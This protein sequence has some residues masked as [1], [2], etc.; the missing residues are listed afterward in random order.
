MSQQ[1]ILW[2]A[3]NS[4]SNTTTQYTNPLGHG[5]TFDTEASQ[6]MIVATGG[7]FSNLRAVLAAAP[8]VGKSW[9]ITLRVNGSSS[10]LTVAISGASTDVSDIAHSVSVSPGDVIA[11]QFTPAGTPA[12]GS[13]PSVSLQFDSTTPGASMYG[14]GSNNVLA[15]TRNNPLFGG[16]TSTN[17][18]EESSVN[19]VE[20]DLTALYVSL[21]GAPG[22]G[23]YTF[24]IEK[25]GTLQDGSGGTVDTRVTITGAGTAGNTSFT[26]PCTPGDL[27]R[28]RGTPS[29][30]GTTRRPRYG[31]AL[32]SDTPGVSNFCASPND[33][34]DATATEYQSPMGNDSGTFNGT[35]SARQATAGVAFVLNHLRFSTNLAP[36]AGKS[37]TLTLRINGSSSAL[38][39]TI[40]DLAT[41]ASDSDTVSIAPNDLVNI[42]IVPT[43]TPL[44][45]AARWAFSQF[46]SEAHPRSFGVIF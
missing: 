28:I 3:S 32:I 39:A 23:S 8:G 22:T 10:A 1:I 42:Q 30:P 38:S 17:W 6:S 40:S 25:N 14:S 34:M 18:S 41:A 12:V 11:L 46:V 20:G 31:V 36:S 4:P 29:S 16:N 33:P 9:T 43:N 19:A 13:L 7:S 44:V 5:A 35:E 21:D 26:L 24:A 37:Y 15:I 2:R 27:F 45:R